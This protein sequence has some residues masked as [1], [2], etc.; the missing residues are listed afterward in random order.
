M[1]GF[2]RFGVRVFLA[3]VFSFVALISVA[4]AQVA[5]VIVEGTI[6]DPSGAAIP[7]VTVTAISTQNGLQKT[8]TS[9]EQGRYTILS[10]P[11]GTYNV[12]AVGQGFATEEERGREFLVGTT[13]TI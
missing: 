10:V 7:N 11:P 4:R 9:D 1:G 5:N 8:G 3:G 12:Q 2:K 6:K 13:V